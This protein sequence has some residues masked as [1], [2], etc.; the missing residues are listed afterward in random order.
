MNK[1][2]KIGVFLLCFSTLAIAKDYAGPYVGIG[3]GVS[4]LHDDSYYKN[5]KDTD[6]SSYNITLGAYINK[7]L[8]VELEYFKSGDFNVLTQNNTSSTFH[9]SAFTINTALHY[10]FYHDKIDCH[11]KF[12]AGQSSMS[13]ST[14]DGSAILYSGGLAYIIAKKYS[15]GVN[16]NLYTFDYKSSARGSFSMSTRYISMNVKMK[17]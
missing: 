5:I 8:A 6:V 17:F 3:Y 7:Y 14:T 2:L 9:Y 1:I 4:T 15:V 10:Y 12:G 16:Y 13:L 11:A